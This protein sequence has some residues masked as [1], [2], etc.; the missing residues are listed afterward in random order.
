MLMYL[1]ANI[2]YRHDYSYDL[3]NKITSLDNSIMF[4]LLINYLC[5]LISSLGDPSILPG[6]CEINEL[7]CSLTFL[8]QYSL[9]FSCF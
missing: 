4:L 9:N 2:S 8:Q 6:K 1:K 3:T 5:S 7:S